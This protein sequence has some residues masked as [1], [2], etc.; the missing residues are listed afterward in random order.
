MKHTRT[1]LFK[2][3]VKPFYLQHVGFFAFLFLILFGAVGVVDGAGIFD[4]H[5]SLIQGIV[6]NP[7]MFLLLL[8]LW[9]LY[10]IKCE[11]HILN[12]FRRPEFAFL[13]SLSLLENKYLYALLVYV[14]LLVFLPLII[15]GMIICFAGIFLHAY[16]ICWILIVYLFGICMLCV[17]WYAY[18]IQQPGMNVA[19]RPRI[20]QTRS[21]ESSYWKFFIRHIAENK[22]LLLLGIKI[23]SCG[24][25]FGMLAN[26]TGSDNELNMIFLFF[27]IAI[28]GHGLIIHQIRE[29]E[30]TRLNFYRTVPVSLAKRFY[31]Y[32]IFYFILLLPEIFTIVMFTPKHLN[33]GH[34]LLFLSFGYSLLLFLHCLLF[35]HVFSMKDY[36]KIVV[37]LFLVIFCSVLT[38]TIGWLCGLL[39]LSSLFIFR[40]CY[41]QFE[42]KVVA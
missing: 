33:Y 40:N 38:A 7:I 35:I 17:R 19:K 10:A 34:A 11:Q 22:K 9:I 12:S 4:F 25:L 29:L 6:K 2:S 21:A 1:I 24:I 15:Y 39:M 37:C 30:E 20:L 23:F 42:L 41:Y 3:L 5:Y 31:Q 18:H 27:C 13:Q 14:Q 36:L 26:Q 16:W 28:L 32:A 8:F